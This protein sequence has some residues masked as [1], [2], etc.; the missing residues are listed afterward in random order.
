[1]DAGADGLSGRKLENWAWRC[2]HEHVGEAAIS[3]DVDQSKNKFK[4]NEWK[5]T[6]SCT[7]AK[8]ELL[9]GD[10]SISHQLR[11]TAAISENGSLEVGHVPAFH[12]EIFE[13]IDKREESEGWENEVDQLDAGES[14]WSCT[15]SEYQIEQQPA[16]LAVKLNLSSSIRKCKSEWLEIPRSPAYFFQCCLVEASSFSCHSHPLAWT[17]SAIFPRDSSTLSAH[18]IILRQPKV[19]RERPQHTIWFQSI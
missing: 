11:C 4:A 2:Q 12:S 6:D 1:M 5:K 13:F 8:Y 9:F 19:I 18:S 17:A 14:N 3:K 15:N 7:E 10:N 16:C